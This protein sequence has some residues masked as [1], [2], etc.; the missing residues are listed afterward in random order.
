ME[1][2]HKAVTASTNDDVADLA[3]QG[4]PHLTTVV[5]DYQTA[6]RGRQGKRWE[7]APR[8]HLLFSIL[9]RPGAD[10]VRWSRIPQIAGMQ[11]IETVE[12]EL[13]PDSDITLKWP[14]D[15][16]HH[17]RKWGGI[18]VES[19]WG[20]KPFA[21]LGMGINCFGTQD[22]F[23]P[24]LRE[25]VTTLEEIFGP[26]S[27]EPFVL[28]RSFHSRLD[29]GLERLLHWFEP[30]VEFVNR[31]NYLRGRTITVASRNHIF[32]GRATGI[33][34][35]GSLILVDDNGQTLGISSGTILAVG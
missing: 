9:L 24:D 1:F 8:S 29:Q 6:G 18:L 19:H 25:S 31:R 2:I 26:S 21:I 3:R 20:A 13:A 22:R 32:R 7:A 23:P 4:Y 30:V 10:P 28:L 16:Y 34:T 12:E 11:W 33:D 14:N 15:L 35:D 17:D 27:L 5:A